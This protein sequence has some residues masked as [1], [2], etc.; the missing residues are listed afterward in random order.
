[1]IVLQENGNLTHN[2]LRAFRKGWY[3]T[4]S[5]GARINKNQKLWSSYTAL[6]QLLDRIYPAVSRSTVVENWNSI[7]NGSGYHW[8]CNLGCA[9]DLGFAPVCNVFAFY[10]MI[11]REIC[12]LIQYNLSRIRNWCSLQSICVDKVRISGISLY[13][14]SVLLSSGRILWLEFRQKRWL[15]IL[16]IKKKT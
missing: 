15:A 11:Y 8:F 6:L 12:P 13:S 9:V 10:K 5:V 2:I 3:W 7:Q 1:M 4:R 16:K 14:I